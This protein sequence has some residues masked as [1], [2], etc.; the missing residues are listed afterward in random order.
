MELTP[1]HISLATGKQLSRLFGASENTIAAWT[2]G[3]QEASGRLI[4]RAARKGIPREILVQGL[5]MRT[6][7]A[8]QK[9]LKR[10]ELEELLETLSPQ[11]QAA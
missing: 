2:V 8:I 7:Y 9:A 4:S 5:D 10:Q 11:L 3:N 1:E 6:N